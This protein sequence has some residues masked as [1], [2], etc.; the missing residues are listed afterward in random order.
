MVCMNCAQVGQ[1][2]YDINQLNESGTILEQAPNLV[3]IALHVITHSL[4]CDTRQHFALD[5]GT[6]RHLDHNNGAD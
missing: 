4:S 6:N 5:R 2:H 1:S 3:V